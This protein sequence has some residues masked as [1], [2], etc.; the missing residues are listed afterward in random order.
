M[1]LLLCFLL[2]SA[3]LSLF[4]KDAAGVHRQALWL[5]ENPDAKTWSDSL[6]TVLS[7]GHEVPAVR[8][9][10]A[11]VFEKEVLNLPK[12]RMGGRIG[13]MLQVGYIELASEP[14]F[15]S[16]TEFEM[17]KAGLTC[18]IRFY[19]NAKRIDPSYS[20]PTMERYAGLLHSDALD[21]YIQAKLRR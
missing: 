16:A 10:T 15:K 1:R 9:G 17:A 21:E 20:V 11:K 13:S 8:H 4:A 6:K 18:M 14:G 19:E 12:D 5:E 2:L 3:P 7:W